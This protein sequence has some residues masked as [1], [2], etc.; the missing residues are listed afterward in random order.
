[1]AL[2]G[3]ADQA[4]SLLAPLAEAPGAPARVRHDFAMVSEIDGDR[5]V[6]EE[7]L[8]PE[9]SPE[10]LQ[11]ALRGYDALSGRSP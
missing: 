10:D 8:Q 9:L 2:S 7:M 1:L 6:A 3:Q 11:A 4:R 5:P